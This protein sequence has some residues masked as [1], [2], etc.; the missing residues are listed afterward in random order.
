LGGKSYGRCAVNDDLKAL[1]DKIEDCDAIILGSPI[2]FGEVT[3]EMRSFLERF[4]FQYLA[5]SKDRVFLTPKKIPSFFIYTMNAPEHVLRQIGYDEKFKQ[6]ANLFGRLIGPSEFFSISD[7][8]Q[9][10]DY[11]KYET[12]MFN[13]EEKIKKRDEEFPKACEKVFETGARIAAGLKA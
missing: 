6:Y 2:Y 4:F 12:S 9:F 5:Y 13:V 8:Y 10:D 11:S 7:T 3:G 1:L